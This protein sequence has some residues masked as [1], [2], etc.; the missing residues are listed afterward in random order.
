MEVRR[1]FEEK[2]FKVECVNTASDFMIGVIVLLYVPLLVAPF[3]II[4]FNMVTALVMAA[5]LLGLVFGVYVFRGNPTKKKGTLL[6]AP[7]DARIGGENSG[8]FNV[9][10]KGLALADERTLRY[11]PAILFETRIRFETAEDCIKAWDLL[12]LV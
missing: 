10:S 3:T 5:L 8:S 6:I 7:G 2:E 4:P 12:K 9:G 11:R 1:R